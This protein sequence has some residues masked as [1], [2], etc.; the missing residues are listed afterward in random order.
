MWPESKAELGKGV[1]KA[2]GIGGT[3]GVKPYITVL[4]DETFEDCNNVTGFNLP[5]VSAFGVAASDRSMAQ[6][7]DYPFEF[8]SRRQSPC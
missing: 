7:D 1:F 4:P 3:V 6:H 5:T 2:S 8:G